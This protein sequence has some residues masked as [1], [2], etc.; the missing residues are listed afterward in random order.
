MGGE[1][2]PRGGT[3]WGSTRD[4]RVL[5]ERGVTS[6][7]LGRYL[8]WGGGTYEAGLSEQSDRNGGS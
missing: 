5:Y 8:W 3:V 2:E 1:G 4:R 6:D 7:R